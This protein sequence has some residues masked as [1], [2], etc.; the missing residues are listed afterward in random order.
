MNRLT[1]VRDAAGGS[2]QYDYDAA[3]NL[4]RVTD[5]NVHPTSFAYDSLN[6]LA[7]VANPL[8]QAKRFF[9]DANRNLAQILDPKGQAITFQ[10]DAANQLKTKRLKDAA[11]VVQDTVAYDYDVLGDLSLV[12]DSDSKLTFEYDSAGRLI[13]AGTGDASNPALAQPVS[14][15][16]YRYDPVG[17]R[18]FAGVS[19]VLVQPIGVGVEYAYDGLNRLTAANSQNLF[20][21][22]FEYDALGRL[23]RQFGGP[24]T[25]FSYD[26]ASH[27]RTLHTLLAGVIDEQFDY[28]YDRVGNRQ[29]LTDRFG[30]H[31]FG[32]DALNRLTSAAHP[33]A[34]GLIP[35]TF[36]YDPVGNRRTSHL[37]T[38]HRLDAANRLLEETVFTYTDDANGNLTSKTTKALPAQTTTYTYDGENQLTRIDL[39]DGKIARYRYDGLGRRIEKQ[40]PRPTSP[41]PE[42]I[43]F[44]YDQEDIW[45]LVD[46]TTNCPT[47]AFLHGPG[48]D[49]P[50]AFVKDT[51][52]DCTFSDA[53]GF[54]EPI[55]YLQTDGLG[56]TTS[57]VSETGGFFRSLFL[58]E[59]YTYDAFG[60][61]TIT[62]PDG[63]PRATSAFG[64]P[65]LFTGREY[66]PESGLY[67]YRARYYD[68]RMGRF[69][70]EDPIRGFLEIP[71][72]QHQ[73]SYVIN[74]PV[75]RIDPKGKLSA[76]IVAAIVG[77]TFPHSLGHRQVECLGG[78]VV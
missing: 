59:R 38:L 31:S 77:V 11:S 19:A 13:R 67:Y 12:Q 39:P 17:N 73:Y 51:N 40:V 78:L 72:T 45:L 49:Q 3:G 48:I 4:L 23:T 1:Q 26:D 20:G 58:A 33:A 35:E 69:L 41:V 53:A 44:L 50:L 61:P 30:F 57:L 74:N 47:H 32:Y 10:Y 2:T 37:S 18:T 64:N 9:Y 29:S 63:T 55:V 5:A 36:T 14:T 54:G 27:L 34:S 28:A 46:G 68:P 6:L 21:G 7:S 66:D 16:S 65:Y 56:S 15:F 25:T 24:P 43:R 75:N 70:Q 8:N 52:G 76:S 22:F 71:L 60:Q 42:V 62:A